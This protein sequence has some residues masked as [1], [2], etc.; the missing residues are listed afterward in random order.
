MKGHRYQIIFPILLVITIALRWEHELFNPKFWS[1]EMAQYI[2]AKSI[3][4][5]HGPSLPV[6]LASD[7]SS[8]VYLPLKQFPEGYS[9]LIAFIW[10]I[11]NNLFISVMGWQWIGVC[12][13]L[14][15]WG[16]LFF[17]FQSHIKSLGVVAF[18]LITAFSLSPWLYYKPTDLLSVSF[19]W[20]ALI[21]FSIGLDKSKI[22]ALIY[23]SLAGFFLFS[24]ITLRYAYQPIVPLTIASIWVLVYFVKSKNRYL[25]AIA[26]TGTFGT[27]W[28]VYHYFIQVKGEL[29]SEAQTKNIYWEN[30]LQADL[31]I[32]NKPI[33][34]DRILHTVFYP[35]GGEGL[36]HGLKIGSSFLILASIIALV[37]L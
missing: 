37:V 22:K 19:Y 33:F 31:S 21:L 25:S 7:F 6:S 15:A 28:W 34:D 13:Y 23:S 32:F 29:P 2:A 27:L 10:Q 24:T 35:L 16:L 11:T 9:Y 36:V 26:M 3:I 17:H 14:L 12:V 8:T 4:E 5:N 30:L 1:D 18:L 20:L